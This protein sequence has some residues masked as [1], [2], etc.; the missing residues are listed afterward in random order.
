MV[1]CTMQYTLDSTQCGTY[2]I[3]YHKAVVHASSA[4]AIRHSVHYAIHYS[5]PYPVQHAERFD[6][7]DTTTNTAHVGAQV[8]FEILSLMVYSPRFA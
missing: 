4:H 2:T 6:K 5:A 7:Y 3:T 8:L 1:R